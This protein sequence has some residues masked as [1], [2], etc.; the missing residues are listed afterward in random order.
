MSNKSKELTEIEKDVIKRLKRKLRDIS[1]G[2]E[3]SLYFADG[4]IN[5]LV[6]EKRITR[7][8]ANELIANFATDEN[9]GRTDM[10]RFE[11]YFDYIEWKYGRVL[12]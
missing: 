5:A 8:F 2:Y 1:Y 12:A 7:K 3:Y 9:C 10:D 11:S 6:A 4:Y